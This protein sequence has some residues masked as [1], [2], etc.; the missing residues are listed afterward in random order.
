MFDRFC[1]RLSENILEISAALVNVQTEHYMDIN[2]DYFP[3]NDVRFYRHQ[4]FYFNKF[5]I[6]LLKES[7]FPE[8]YTVTA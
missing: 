5:R 1:E 6:L 2:W 7:N 8:K 4:Q 3:S